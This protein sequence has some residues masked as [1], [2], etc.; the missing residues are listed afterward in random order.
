MTRPDPVRC[1]KWRS[2]VLQHP[3]A[4]LIGLPFAEKSKQ[5]MPVQALRKFAERGRHKEQLKKIPGG[6]GNSLKLFGVG[7]VRWFARSAPGNPA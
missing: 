5:G 3:A 2:G 6:G 4:A 1:G 7:V